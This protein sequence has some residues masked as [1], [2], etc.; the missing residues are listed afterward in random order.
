VLEN[1]EWH[2]VDGASA[3]AIAR[4][5]ATAPASLPESYFALLTFSNGG[6]GPLP[7]QPLWLCLY[8]AEEVTEIEQTGTFRESFPKLFVIGG[9]GGGEAVA[10]DMR[11]N[12]PY[13]IIAF[14][15]TNSDPATSIQEIT[16]SFDAALT[17][18]GLDK[19]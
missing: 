15:M 17:L 13:P 4:L 8:S 16:G 1:R 5:R 3:A 9:N 10:F 19:S 11:A 2:R 12:E 7:V 14:D 6:E 18:I